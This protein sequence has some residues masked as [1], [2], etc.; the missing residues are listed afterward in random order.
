MTAY[1][2]LSLLFFI[3]LTIQTFGQRT[4]SVMTIGGITG[5]TGWTIIA[6]IPKSKFWG[7]SWHLSTAYNLTKTNEFH[8]NI[9]RTY[10]KVFGGGGGF[11]NSMRS[12]GLGYDMTTKGTT[13]E[14][15]GQVFYGDEFFYMAIGAGYRA[16]YI[17]NFTDNTHYLRPSVGLSFFFVDIF[18]NYSFNLNNTNDFKHG[19]TFRLQYF[20]GRKKWE[21]WYPR[22]C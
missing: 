1:H 22:R 10:G 12:W 3:G 16:D 9:G 2:R 6:N 7:N 5:D 20:L 18:Y 15:L 21:T 13:T 19:V 4:D 8:F 14:Q 17:Y 11:M